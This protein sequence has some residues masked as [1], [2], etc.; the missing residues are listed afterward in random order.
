MA[1][2]IGKEAWPSPGCRRGPLPWS[3]L[4]T[5][6]LSQGWL[7]APTGDLPRPLVPGARHAEASGCLPFSW[8]RGPP[9]TRTLASPGN[10]TPPPPPLRAPSGAATQGP[11]RLVFR[12][13]ELTVANSAG[14]TVHTAASRPGPRVLP[15]YT[16]APS[17]PRPCQLSGQG[18]RSRCSRNFHPSRGSALSLKETGDHEQKWL[19]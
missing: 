14:I 2:Q 5:A 19:R 4:P 1:S 13:R 7:R 10:P 8:L 12:T 15:D 9:G 3:V 11:P 16:P 17:A 18:Q 6:H